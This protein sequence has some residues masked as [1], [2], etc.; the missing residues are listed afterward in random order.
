MSGGVSVVLGGVGWYLR[1]GRLWV[2]FAWCWACLLVFSCGAVVRGGLVFG[3]GRRCC[4]RTA[5]CGLVFFARCLAIVRS[6]M[7]I[8]SHLGTTHRPHHMP[9]LLQTIP[10][11]HFL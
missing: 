1:F 4:L 8:L 10:R 9:V 3:G 6:F 7:R 2:V 5:A 11:L